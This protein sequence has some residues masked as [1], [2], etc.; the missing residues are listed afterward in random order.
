M[1]LH[2][3]DA[4]VRLMYHEFQVKAANFCERVLW[5]SLSVE[6]LLSDC[7]TQTVGAL[8]LWLPERHQMRVTGRFLFIGP[9]ELSLLFLE[10]L[11]QNLLYREP[12]ARESLRI[13]RRLVTMVT[14]ISLS[15]SHPFPPW[16][17]ICPGCSFRVFRCNLY[18]AVLSY[19][20]VVCLFFFFTLLAFSPPLPE[21][22]TSFEK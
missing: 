6:A 8:N 5:E 18:A 14:P 17:C 20:F 22:K 4:H 21:K 12:E 9:F 19:I 1:V 2:G 15:K 11:I 3:G 10:G 16:W 13:S 7:G